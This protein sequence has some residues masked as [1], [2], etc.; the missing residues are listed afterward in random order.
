M[1]PGRRNS[2]NY[3]FE[4]IIPMRRNAEDNKGI[5]FLFYFILFIYLY[6]KEGNERKIHHASNGCVD[7]QGRPTDK[8]STG[9]WKSALF[10]IGFL[11]PPICVSLMFYIFFKKFER[12]RDRLS[13]AK[14]S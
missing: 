11:N 5:N 12:L 14:I 3:S 9:G 8:R 10:I 7:F 1:Q 13:S 4:I 2:A 6:F